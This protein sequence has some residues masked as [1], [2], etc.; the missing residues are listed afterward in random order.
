MDAYEAM[1]GKRSMD[2]Q[3]HPPELALGLPSVQIHVKESAASLSLLE[4]VLLLSV[5]GR[6]SE[7]MLECSQGLGGSPNWMWVLRDQS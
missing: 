7:V 6:D 4:W 3:R 2:K 5:A 1:T